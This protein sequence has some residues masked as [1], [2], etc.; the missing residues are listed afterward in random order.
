MSTVPY[1]ISIDDLAL[2]IGILQI[3]IDFLLYTPTQKAPTAITL[4]ALYIRRTST[5]LV[6]LV[7]EGLAR[8][9]IVRQIEPPLAYYFTADTTAP[10]TRRPPQ[11]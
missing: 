8:L 6:V 2:L 11:E 1:Q 4:Q 5:L 7:C 10:T 9:R 3:K